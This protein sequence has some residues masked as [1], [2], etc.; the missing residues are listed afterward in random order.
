LAVEY[1]RHEIRQALA[2][3]AVMSISATA[4]VPTVWVVGD[5][6]ANKGVFEVGVLGVAGAFVP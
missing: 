6:T 3:M 1:E 5:S 4:Q 2:A